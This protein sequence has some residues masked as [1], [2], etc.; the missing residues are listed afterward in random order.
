MFLWVRNDT[1]E[2]L[3]DLRTGYFRHEM[4]LGWKKFSLAQGKCQEQIVAFRGRLRQHSLVRKTFP[5]VVLEEGDR[6]CLSKLFI[7]GEKGAN[8]FLRVNQRINT[9]YRKEFLGW[10]TYWLRPHGQPI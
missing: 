4:S 8:D 3:K 6:S 10:K 1:P 5:T 2:N 7:H 9:F